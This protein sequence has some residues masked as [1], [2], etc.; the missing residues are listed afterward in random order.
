MS[1]FLLGRWRGPRN[2]LI[3]SAPT[4]SRY[5]LKV[6][7]R[8]PCVSSRRGRRGSSPPD[9][10]QTSTGQSK[11]LP[12]NCPK[13]FFFLFFFSHTNWS[14]LW[15]QR[16]VRLLTHATQK[17]EPA[18]A[19][20]DRLAC[21]SQR[22]EENASQRNIRRVERRESGRTAEQKLVPLVGGVMWHADNFFMGVWFF[23]NTEL[24]LFKLC[25]KGKKKKKKKIMQFWRSNF[26]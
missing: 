4:A 23:N 13:H 1:L 14:P 26:I 11:P 15:H 3:S 17:H 24:F 16:W 10:S 19:A 22:D 9:G 25:K 6:Y 20:S 2:V 7:R 18:E 5:I 8:K 12:A 21:L